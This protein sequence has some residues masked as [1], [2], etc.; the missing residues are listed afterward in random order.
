MKL[1][2]N[3]PKSLAFFLIHL[4]AV[5]MIGSFA[6][7]CLAQTQTRPVPISVTINVGNPFLVG[8]GSTPLP[9]N[10]Q[11]ELL[12]YART[13]RAILERALQ[14]ALPLDEDEAT[15]LFIRALR[16][17]V[18]ASAVRHNQSELLMR[19]AANQAL[20]LVY[21]VPTADGNSLQTSPALPAQSNLSA[22]YQILINSIDLAMHYFPQD[23][24]A[25]SNQ[26]YLA[27]AVARLQLA[28]DW[29]RRIPLLT[30][31]YVFSAKVLEQ[32]LNVIQNE[33]NVSLARVADAILDAQRKLAEYSA[34][35][36]LV[37]PQDSYEVNRR[38]RDLRNTV[39]RLLNN[40][41]T[42]IAEAANAQAV[43]T[44]QAAADTRAVR[45]RENAI[46]VAQIEQAVQAAQTERTHEEA[47]QPPPGGGYEWTSDGH[48]YYRSLGGAW[49]ARA[50]DA[51]C[52]Q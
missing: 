41:Q 8:T 9:A 11:S 26:N 47:N 37:M 6:L 52:A 25:I 43:M 20:E 14:E 23:E 22:K 31:Q 10:L 2:N 49:G 32:F 30:D 18:P 34:G 21:G 44:E 28:K 7:P 24:A 5:S 12:A 51:R 1:F 27:F 17:M 38:V 33:H 35:G 42:M 29:V 46:L 13:S 19:I 4:T 36:F 16:Q 40:L 3:A 39:S 50:E 45:A 48:C 15:T